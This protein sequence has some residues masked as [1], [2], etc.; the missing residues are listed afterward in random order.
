MA[1]FSMPV[2]LYFGNFSTSNFHVNIKIMEECMK[3][4]LATQEYHSM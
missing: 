3:D 1:N 4:L 2:M